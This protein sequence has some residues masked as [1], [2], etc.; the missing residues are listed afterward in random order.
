M[1]ALFLS[2]CHHSSLTF[3]YRIIID[4][5]MGTSTG[6]D[7]IRTWVRLLFGTTAIR[8]WSYSYNYIQQ[9]YLTP[10]LSRRPVYL[11]TWSDEHFTG[12]LKSLHVRYLV[13][14]PS[15]L[16]P[17]IFPAILRASSPYLAVHFTGLHFL[18]SVLYLYFS[19]H[20]LDVPLIWMARWRQALRTTQSE[21]E[22]SLGITSHDG[23]TT[24]ASDLPLNLEW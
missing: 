7:A 5:L 1:C 15:L 23:T 8:A 6:F 21:R 24:A 22:A 2:T 3:T 14:S 11:A 9:Q 20:I 17:T 13:S 18:F 4:R 12:S 16:C 10:I 19:A